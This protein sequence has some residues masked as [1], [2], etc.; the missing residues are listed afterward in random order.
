VRV[1]RGAATSTDARYLF[2]AVLRM[3][4]GD[5]V[6]GYISWTIERAEG[7]AAGEQ[8]RENVEGTYDVTLGALDIHGTLSTNPLVYPVNAY[9]F[10]TR[11]PRVIDGST[12]DAALVLVG[13]LAQ[14]SPV[15]GRDAGAR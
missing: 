1:W 10:R 7:V 9:R 4:H 13:T 6:S 15:A 12:L 14:P 3:G 8:V 11:G 2:A 5:R